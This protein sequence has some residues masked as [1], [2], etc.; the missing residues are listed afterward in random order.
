MPEVSRYVISGKILTLSMNEGVFGKL[1]NRLGMISGR[2]IK[3]MRL[4]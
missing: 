2:N 4:R 3:H 1:K